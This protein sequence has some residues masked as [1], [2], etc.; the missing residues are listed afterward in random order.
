M[1]RTSA[2]D[3]DLSTTTLMVRSAISQQPAAHVAGNNANWARNASSSESVNSQDGELVETILKLNCR[4][5]GR[6]PSRWL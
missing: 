1:E 4:H 6:Q 5:I 2:L 3:E